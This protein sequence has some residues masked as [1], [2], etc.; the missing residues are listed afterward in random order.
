MLGVGPCGGIEKTSLISL[1]SEERR[2]RPAPG[3]SIISVAFRRNHRHLLCAG[4]DCA[5]LA[6][7]A[8]SAAGHEI[9]VNA[10]AF[11]TEMREFL[12]NLYKEIS[13]ENSRK[14]VTYRYRRA[15]DRQSKLVLVDLAMHRDAHA[16]PA[17]LRR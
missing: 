2:A 17:S 11:T 15:E 10:Y 4:Q 8:I 3:A 12:G 5:G 13:I 16:G 1:T 7:N 6:I 9:L 14:L